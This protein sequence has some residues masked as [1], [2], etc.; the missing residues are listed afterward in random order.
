MTYDNEMTKLAAEAFAKRAAKAERFPGHPHPE[1]CRREGDIVT[2]A[3]INGKVLA[4]YKVQRNRACQERVRLVDR[5]R[6][7]P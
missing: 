4:C 7:S 5:R 2:L 3:D 6:A 1:H